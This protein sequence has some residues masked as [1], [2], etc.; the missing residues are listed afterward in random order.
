MEALRLWTEGSAWFSNES[1]KKGL[2]KEGCYADFIVP[3]ADYF[4]VEEEEIKDIVSLLTVVGGKIVY[5][6]RIFK[7]L[8]PQELQASPEWSPVNFF[9]GYQAVHPV[10]EPLPWE[11]SV[12]S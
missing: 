7:S 1:G 8:A 12:T 11:T 5:G 2:I 3:S 9:G 6:D 4:S 10:K